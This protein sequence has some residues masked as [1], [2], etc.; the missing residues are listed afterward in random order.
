MLIQVTNRST[1]TVYTISADSYTDALKA[2][3]NRGA[4]LE[5]ETYS[6]K[7]IPGTTL[8]T[9]KRYGHPSRAVV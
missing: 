3:R 4:L 7:S 9:T 5:G 2:L 1:E 8:L 6:V